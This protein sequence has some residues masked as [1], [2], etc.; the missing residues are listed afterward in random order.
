MHFLSNLG[1]H[2][3]KSLNIINDMKREELILCIKNLVDIDKIKDIDYKISLIYSS[4]FS[5]R[6]KFKPI[7][8]SYK[9]LAR[10]IIEDGFPDVVTWNKIAN[11]EGYYSSISLQYI[12]NKTWKE[13]EKEITKEIKDILLS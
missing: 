6:Q 12:K 9:K 7:L 13:I 3:E 4:Y 2:F 8:E 5:D 10:L 11:E 1:L